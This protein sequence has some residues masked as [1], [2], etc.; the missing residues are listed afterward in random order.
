MQ[1]KIGPA[2]FGKAFNDYANWWF[3]WVR[4]ILQNSIDSKGCKK[5]DVSIQLV[6]G[7]TVIT[8]QNDGQPMSRETLVDKLLSIGE[9]DKNF[10]DGSVGGF[11]R[12]KELLYFCHKSWQIATGE[13]VATGSGG[14]YDLVDIPYLHGTKSVVR[15][16]G[17]VSEAIA[18]NFRRFARLSQWSGTLTV[19][20]VQLT[21][22]LHK[23]RS[24]RSFAF[25]R[26]YTNRSFSNLVVV[27]IGGIPM[28]TKSCSYSGCVVLELDGKSDDLLT[29][30]RDSLV[31]KHSREFD[32][33][34]VDL[35]T[36]KRAAFGTPTTV[37][38]RFAGSKQ[39]VR[40]DDQAE[41]TGAATVQ[42]A[43]A[44]AVTSLADV[45]GHINAVS[46]SP[47]GF[48]SS[49]DDGGNPH[50]Y[51]FVVKNSTGMSTP[52]YYFPNSE[53]FSSHNK[54]LA[55]FWL[56]ILV[57]LHK[58]FKNGSTFSIGFILDED[59]A[60]QYEESKKYGRVY[61]LNPAKIVRQAK[62]ASRSFARRFK[63]TNRNELIALA[64]HEFLHG[65]G[66]HGHDENFASGFT[67]AM[68]VVLDNRDSFNW[69]FKN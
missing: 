40:T 11:G 29:S 32:Q 16:Q 41:V 25:G 56:N 58:I 2:F 52:S 1:V 26:V 15:M 57:Q 5:I 8:V 59:C 65:S 60:A 34:L 17:D 7:D 4:E 14:T 69:C 31:H 46:S 13:V 36:N 66:Y 68:S 61:Y 18:I 54:K 10:A 21:C 12:A 24:R 63:L 37:Y 30:N 23:G 22:G 33:F 20:G 49:Y 45:A 50:G 38:H 48:S 6:D 28:F 51:E 9:S 42:V 3:A 53:T 27:R 19:D 55:R 39:A 62:S 67:G 43:V 64:L 44:D 35:S 47:V